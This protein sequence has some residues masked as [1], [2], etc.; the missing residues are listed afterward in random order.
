MEIPGR[1]RL[2]D[3]AVRGLE[4]GRSAGNRRFL[5]GIV[6]R[7]TFRGPRDLR[8]FH[9]KHVATRKAR[10]GCMLSYLSFLAGRRLFSGGRDCWMAGT[11]RSCSLT[12]ACSG[13]L[14]REARSGEGPQCKCSTWN[15]AGLE[16]AAR[17]GHCSCRSATPFRFG[18]RREREAN[19][20]AIKNLRQGAVRLTP[21]E[22]AAEN[23]P[24][25]TFH[26]GGGRDSSE[27][28]TL[29]ARNCDMGQTGA[30]QM[31]RWCFTWNILD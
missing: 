16:A 28:R 31:R 8:L 19:E 4:R 23:V 20:V 21:K 25:G 24:R 6:S 12:G 22:S 30:D 27:V 10:R 7:G 29:E 13:R 18:K 26:Q 1:K 15:M 9:V 3:P 14:A 5:G 17:R 2:A 11:V